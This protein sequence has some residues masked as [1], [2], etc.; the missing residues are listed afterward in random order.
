[1]QRS[2]ELT[3][4]IMLSAYA[5]DPQTV[6]S[7]WAGGQSNPSTKLAQAPHGS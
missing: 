5:G 3:Q 1:M 2:K 4:R 6:L 7:G